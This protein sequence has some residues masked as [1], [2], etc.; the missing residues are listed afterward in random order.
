[1]STTVH[2]PTEDEEMSGRISPLRGAD[3][4][5]DAKRVGR[6][7]LGGCLVAVLVTAVVLFVAGTNKNAQI[8][9]LHERGVPVEVTVT[10]CLGLLGGSGSNA[11]GYA[12]TGTFTLGGQRFAE[13]IPGDTFHAPGSTLR[14]V[15]VAGN[16]PLLSTASAVASEHASWTVFV[17][18]GVLLVV[19]VL[20][21]GAVVLRRRRRSARSLLVLGLG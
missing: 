21:L 8:T 14:G 1:M 9:A 6:A 5:V 18:P 12:C 4:A 11:A 10:K 13:A 15:A 17:V 20:A 7:V 3:V 16:P 19:L 2:E